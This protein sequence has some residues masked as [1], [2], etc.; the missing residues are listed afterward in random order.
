MEDEKVVEAIPEIGFIHRGLEEL[1][2][3]RDFTTYVSICERICGICSFGHSLGY[4][5]TVEILMGIDVPP[6]AEFLRVIW[7]ELSRI[8]SHMLW[9]GLL[10]DAFGY[11]NLFMQCFRLR[12]RVL[13]IFEKTTGGR[14]ILSACCVGGVNQDITNEDLHGIVQIL[15]NMRDEYNELLKTFLYDSSVKSRL[16]G[17]GYLSEQ[18]ARDLCVVG[19]F[20]RASNIAED[21]RMFGY[22]GYGALSNFEPVLSTSGDGYGRSEVRAKEILQ[23]MDII[24]ELVQI[25]PDGDI[26]VKVKGK[27]EEGSCAVS[28]LEQPR[29]ECF[30]YSRGNGTRFLDRFRIRTPT[31]QNLGGMTQILQGCDLADVPLNILT[32][33]PCISCSER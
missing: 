27:P 24:K 7:H 3:K 18:Q 19:P 8:H 11:E 20:A 17:V 22:G 2:K 10:A 32:I 25:I 21:V 26:A 31:S 9:L 1:V 12:E 33:D 5:Q 6:R 4:C 15:D 16:V 30:Y 13:D 14:V 23:S 29:G 28:R